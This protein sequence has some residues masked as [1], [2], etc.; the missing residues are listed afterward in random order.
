MSNRID[1]EEDKAE[2][3]YNH[4]KRGR[5]SSFK[6][7]EHCQ[8]LIRVMMD[9]NRGT[10]SAFCVAATIDEQTFY[11]WINKHEMFRNIYFFSKMLARENWEHDGRALRDADF[12]MGTVNY[13]FEYWKMI[14]WSR[15]GI[16]KNSRI[17]M[18]LKSDDS[19]A[20]HYA[21][22]LKQACDGDFTASEFKQ[23]MEAVNVG[24]NVH[25][26]FELQKQIDELKSALVT[27]EQNAGVQ[28][29][30]S[31]KGTS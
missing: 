2:K 30:F 14:G 22:I 24:I 27:M 3:I 17:K 1:F 16:S 6:E 31:N 29:P 19:P 20:Q 11:N 10:M 5:H 25:Q 21:A 8:L 7:K 26:V 15:F 4:F 12:P 18:N 28:N 9:R 23:L 13:S